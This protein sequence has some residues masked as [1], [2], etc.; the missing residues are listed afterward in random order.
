[1]VP[2]EQKKQG[3]ARGWGGGSDRVKK[4][5]GAWVCALGEKNGVSKL[6]L[7][8]GKTRHGAIKPDKQISAEKFPFDPKKKVR[9]RRERWKRHQGGSKPCTTG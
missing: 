1:M 6:D 5:L 7:S 3:F 4:K 9:W 8:W 2:S